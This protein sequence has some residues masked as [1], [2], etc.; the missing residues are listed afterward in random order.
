MVQKVGEEEYLA[1][2]TMPL[3]EFARM[4]AFTPLSKEAVTVSGYV[5]RLLG[6]VPETGSSFRI[7]DWIGV[8]DAVERK[9]A[10]AIRMRKM[11]INKPEE[12]SEPGT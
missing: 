1:D 6:K 12:D 11:P 7:G 8:V 9:K 2:G 10:K 5:I 3:H 4:F